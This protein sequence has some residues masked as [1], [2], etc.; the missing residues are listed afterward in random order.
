MGR[1]L[2]TGEPGSARKIL[3]LSPKD[4][5]AVTRTVIGEAGGQG[6]AGMSGV[7]NVIRNR[8]EAGFAPS[9]SGV[10]FE[11]G[12]IEPWMH[13]DT[14]SRLNSIS[15]D[16]PEYNK[17]AQIVD[18]VFN[19][20]APD[21]TKGATHFYAPALQA[22][23]GRYDPAWAKTFPATAEIGG[24]IF[25]QDPQYAKMLGSSLQPPQG[26]QTVAKISPRSTVST[27]D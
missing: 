27:E 22:K 10:V 17:A 14:A 16:N 19:G 13:S 18:S 2:Q 8:V 23:L 4:R 25:Y 5:D 15:P 11:K 3:S 21:N 12:Q 20:T 6:D 9:A 24:H 26:V 7:A 1:P